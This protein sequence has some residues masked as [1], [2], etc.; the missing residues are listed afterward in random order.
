MQYIKKHHPHAVELQAVSLM[1]KSQT[2][3]EFDIQKHHHEIP[4]G[5]EI[6][7]RRLPLLVRNILY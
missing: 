6:K 5:W 2:D 7:P 4:H 1:L 3:V